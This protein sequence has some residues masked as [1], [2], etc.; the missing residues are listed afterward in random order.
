LRKREARP[1]R[2]ASRSRD[3]RTA[4]RALRAF[5]LRFPGAT[6]DFPWGERVVKAGGKVFV[7]LGLDPVPGGPMS[8]SVKLPE[9]SEE[10][11][12]LPFVRPTGYGLGKAGWI[13]ATLEPPAR[14][15]VDLLK[16]WIAESYRAVA[17]KKLAAPV[18]SQ[19][20]AKAAKG[21]PK[22]RRFESV[23]ESG[24]KGAAVVVPFDPGQIWGREPVEIA[25]P[26]YGKAL[27]HPVRG[28]IAGVAFEGW[29]GRRW[30]RFF[31]LVDEDLRRRAG[32]STGSP[33]TVSIAPAPDR[34]AVIRRKAK[35]DDR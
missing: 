13:T 31:I 14:P 33:V 28:T 7:F 10:A 18:A 19:K 23:L 15:P 12:E 17:P 35:E 5:A 4:A 20:N 30:G 16:A 9:S 24:H 27:G 1:R 34:R 6:E 25:T 29:I 3:L 11:R 21:R 2:A 8:L 32:I 26:V 22:R